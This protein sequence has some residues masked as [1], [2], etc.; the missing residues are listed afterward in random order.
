VAIVISR[1]RRSSRES[2]QI[3]EERTKELQE[4]EDKYRDLF[5]QASDLIQSVTPDGAF[6][7]VNPA[8]KESLGYSDE[9]IAHL[10]LFDIIH[11]DSQ[12]YCQEMFH[13]IMAGEKL[14]HVEAKFVTKAGDTITVEGSSSCKFDHGKPVSTRGIFHDITMRKKAEEKLKEQEEKLRDSNAELERFNHLTVGREIRMIELK[15]RI[16]E[17]SGELGREAPYDPAYSEE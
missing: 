16:N 9:E 4:S 8:W 17:L 10:S 2:E 12:V 1:L 7:Y 15:K 3:V 13:R 11:P 6:D 14:N 5:E